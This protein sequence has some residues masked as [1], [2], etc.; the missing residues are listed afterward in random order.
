MRFSQAFTGNSYL[1]NTICIYR[2]GP[3][4]VKIVKGI[5]IAAGGNITSD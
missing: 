1:T 4:P 5:Y 2:E 3:K